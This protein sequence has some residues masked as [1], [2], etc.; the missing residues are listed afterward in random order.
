[1]NPEELKKKSMTLQKELFLWYYDV[2]LPAILPREFWKEDIR[3]YRLLTDACEIAGKQKVLVTVASEAF[4][5]LMWENCR[6]K[7]VNYFVLKDTDP[8]APV[9]SGKHEDAS[10]HTAKWSDGNSG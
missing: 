7:W 3:H 6:D 2:W 9:P 5:L 10:K 8:T 4:G 1:M